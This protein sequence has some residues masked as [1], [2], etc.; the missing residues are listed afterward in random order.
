MRKKTNPY[1]QN[2][3]PLRLI[4]LALQIISLTAA[5]SA[6]KPIAMACAA[7]FATLCVLSVLYFDYR[8]K[9]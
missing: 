6:N 7:I 1:Q 5:F 3:L 4:A 8:S 9:Q 2:A